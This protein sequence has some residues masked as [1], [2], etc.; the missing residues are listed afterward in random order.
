MDHDRVQQ[1]QQ[2]TVT[3]VMKHPI[4]YT[5]NTVSTSWQ[6]SVSKHGFRTMKLIRTKVGKCHEIYMTSEPPTLI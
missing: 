3:M 5:T 1:Q 2:A 4:P 6:L